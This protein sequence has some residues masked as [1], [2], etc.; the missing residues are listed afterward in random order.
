M[1]EGNRILRGKVREELLKPFDN[2]SEMRRK[3]Q[4]PSRGK[5]ALLVVLLPPVPTQSGEHFSHL[6]GH[7][8]Q[9]LITEISSRGTFQDLCPA[10]YLKLNCTSLWTDSH[11]PQCNGNN[12]TPYAYLWAGKS[13]RSYE[14][15]NQ[16]FLKYN[17]WRWS[18]LSWHSSTS[19]QSLCELNFLPYVFHS[20]TFKIKIIGSESH[21]LSGDSVILFIV[22][23]AQW[24][25]M[26]STWCLKKSVSLLMP[27]KVVAW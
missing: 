18:S 16:R 21:L 27:S 3:N 5:A 19:L 14:A 15:W 10:K 4:N 17:A 2:C 9:Y 24:W 8:W 23:S 25:C 26:S 6:P 11:Y 1:Q 22:I 20:F 7:S 13:L 12:R